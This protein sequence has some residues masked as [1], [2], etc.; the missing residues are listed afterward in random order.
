VIIQ[1]NKVSHNIVG[2][3]FDMDG[4]LIE[5]GHV[6]DRVWAAWAKRFNVSD[7]L[8]ILYGQPSIATVRECFPGED[9]AT[10]SM[11]HR[12]ADDMEATD[13]DGVHAKPG[14]KDLLAR[15]EQHG[16]AWAIVTSADARLAH[17]RLTAAGI[18]PPA[19]VTVDDVHFGKPHPEPYLLGASLIGVPIE[20]CLVVEDQP[21]GITSG[22]AAGAITAGVWGVTGDITVNSLHAL[23]QQLQG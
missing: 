12:A 13:V 15:L 5:S 19:L 4:T 9:E 2:V 14:A 23:N 6:V 20:H 17:A 10:I 21:A 7:R 22:R 1:G 16:I 11:L 18:T 3:L 8:T